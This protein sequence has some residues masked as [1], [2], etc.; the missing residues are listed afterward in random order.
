MDCSFKSG[1]I[2]KCGKSY[3]GV[4]LYDTCSKEMGSGVRTICYRD[5]LNDFCWMVFNR[6]NVKHIFEL[7]ENVSFIYDLADLFKHIRVD[8]A[9]LKPDGTKVSEYNALALLGTWICEFE[10]ELTKLLVKSQNHIHGRWVDKESFIKAYRRAFYIT[11]YEYD[12][13][14][15]VSSFYEV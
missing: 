7:P 8:Y 4:V 11:C 3:Y 12:Y 1:D 5:K 15:F 10:R 14:D 13:T 6:E 9:F 2:V